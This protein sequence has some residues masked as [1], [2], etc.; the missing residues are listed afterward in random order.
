MKTNK[1]I[2]DLYDGVQCLSMAFNF[3]TKFTFFYFISMANCVTNLKDN[4]N[5][6]KLMLLVG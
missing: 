5:I 6:N 4:E 3:L 2:S 1:W